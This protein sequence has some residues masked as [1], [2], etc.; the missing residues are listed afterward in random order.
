MVH[1]RSLHPCRINQIRSTR[2]RWL[3]LPCYYLSQ[4]SFPTCAV[5]PGPSGHP[6]CS[7]P[8][9]CTRVTSWHLRTGGKHWWPEN[10]RTTSS[11]QLCETASTDTVLHPNSKLQ[12]LSV[13]PLRSPV[14][15]ALSSVT[16]LRQ[17]KEPD[18]RWLLMQSKTKL[19]WE[20]PGIWKHLFKTGMERASCC[21]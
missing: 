21:L 8:V 12:F 7:C 10:T 3:F 5:F 11:H 14:Q 19:H 20:P 13:M 2:C 4:R 16:T 17:S 18:K 9:G 1:F 15:Y 6:L